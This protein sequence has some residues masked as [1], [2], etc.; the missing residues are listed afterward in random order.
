MALLAAAV[1]PTV[2]R[3]AVGGK[4]ARR[5]VGAGTHAERLLLGDTEGPGKFLHKV[6][7]DVESRILQ[8][9][10]AHTAKVGQ[11]ESVDL[12]LTEGRIALGVRGVFRSPLCGRV[13]RGN[14]NLAL[15]LRGDYLGKGT[16]HVLFLKSGHDVALEILRHEVAAV[17]VHALGQHVVNEN[18]AAKV[19]VEVLLIGIGRA[20]CLVGLDGR[21]PLSGASVIGWFTGLLSSASMASLRSMRLISLVRLSRSCSILE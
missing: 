8:K 17:S 11:L 6:V 2:D 5:L 1:T 12:L 4:D 3:A 18:L 15:M 9:F 13:S 10:H 21:S 19:A 14:G 7:L 20:T 16:D